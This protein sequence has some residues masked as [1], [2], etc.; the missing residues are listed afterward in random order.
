MKKS[1]TIL[2]ILQSM[3]TSEEVQSEVRL[4]KYEDNARKFTVY[5]LL[6]LVYGCF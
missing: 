6:L 2:S 3:L 5:H 4:A 1:T